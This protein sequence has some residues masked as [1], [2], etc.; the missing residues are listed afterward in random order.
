MLWR[1]GIFFK[2]CLNIFVKGRLISINVLVTFLS[3]SINEFLQNPR[4]GTR[5]KF[6]E[7]VCGF[8]PVFLEE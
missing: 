3:V 5:A 8:F 4:D 7:L 6:T 2:Y 1:T